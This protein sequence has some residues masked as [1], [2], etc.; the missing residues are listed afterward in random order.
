MKRLLTKQNLMLL[1]LILPL[2]LLLTACSHN[3]RGDRG[4]N[5]NNKVVF[6]QLPM[7][8]PVS[9]TGNSRIKTKQLQIAP[10]ILTELLNQQGI[11]YQIDPVRYVVASYNYWGSALDQQLQQQLI[12][13]LTQ[14]LPNYL[15][16]SQ[17]SL[18][19]SQVS[20]ITVHVDQF[21]GRYD[22]SAVISGHWLWQTEKGTQQHPFQ[23]ALYQPTDGYDGLVLTL[24]KGWQQLAQSIATS[25]LAQ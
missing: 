1:P 15:V 23:F 3:N 6:Y 10:V 16:T 2:I 24:A 25:V 19:S 18:I 13:Q 17:P 22:G 9:T 11:V 14:A 4:R 20:K 8:T 21:N 12:S 5:S 7:M